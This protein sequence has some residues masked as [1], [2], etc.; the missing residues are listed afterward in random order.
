MMRP[1]PMIF[2]VPP[3]TITIIGRRNLFGVEIYSRWKHAKVEGPGFRC[4][5]MSICTRDEDDGRSPYFWNEMRRLTESGDKRKR[6]FLIETDEDKDDLQPTKRQRF[7]TVAENEPTAPHNDDAQEDIGNKRKRGFLIETDE[8]KDD[9]QPTKRQR[10]TTVAEN[11][12]TAPHNDD[13]QE[14]IGNNLDD[15]LCYSEDNDENDDGD[16]DSMLFGL[17]FVDDEPLLPVGVLGTEDNEDDIDEEQHDEEKE[18]QVLPSP[19]ADKEP[20]IEATDDE[21]L[22]M[23]NIDTNYNNNDD[24][25]VVDGEDDD[26]EEEEEVPP[27]TPPSP[28]QQ[29]RRSRRI[30]ANAVT[31]QV[32]PPPPLLLLLLQPLLRRSAR[33]AL[34]PRVS[35]VGMF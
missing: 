20:L 7:T 32:P 31:T 2:R 23:D 8:D 16:D 22:D 1:I 28:P 6:G 25:E 19:P 15:S 3:T 13:A 33:L 12:P 11:E 14:D 21:P 5:D 9:L 10:F 24:H 4:Y 30:A 26:E 18:V 27:A 34:I 29:L 17:A 35:Y